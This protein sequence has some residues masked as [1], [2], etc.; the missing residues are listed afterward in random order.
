MHWS[1]EEYVLMGTGALFVVVLLLGRAPTVSLSR[2]SYAVFSAAAA[3][4]AVA[5]VLLATVDDVWYPRV[6][7][8]LPVIPAIE[9]AILLRDALHR[10]DNA[11]HVTELVE[12]EV[13]EPGV[14]HPVISI[15]RPEAKPFPRS[16]IRR[17]PHPADDAAARARAHNPHTDATVLADLAYGYPSLRAAVAGNPATPAAVLDWLAKSGDP[18]V[19]AAIAA[20]GSSLS[21]RGRHV[22][23]P[24]AV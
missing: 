20:R 1:A 5:A 18:V 15:P 19:T 8:L 16:E 3:I 7:W 11:V 6:L 4:C 14:D 24:T 17:P 22:N 13:G 10:Q 21:M 9:I 2:F 23:P 12:F